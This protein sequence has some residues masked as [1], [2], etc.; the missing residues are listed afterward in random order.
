[1]E[2]K[3]GKPAWRRWWLGLTGDEFV[4]VGVEESTEAAGPVETREGRVWGRAPAS[5]KEATGPVR[6]PGF[7]GQAGSVRPT[8]HTGSRTQH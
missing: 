7:L 3:S 2:V 4:Q 1:M 8:S 5:S 6:S